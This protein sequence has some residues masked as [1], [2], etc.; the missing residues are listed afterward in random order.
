LI[1]K[2]E[3]REKRGVTERGRKG[4]RFSKKKKNKK[5]REISPPSPWKFVNAPTVRRDSSMH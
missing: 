4:K 1:I 3:G 2:G 5:E